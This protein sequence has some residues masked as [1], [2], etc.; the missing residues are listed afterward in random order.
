VRVLSRG[1]THH[2]YSQ[3]EVPFPAAHPLGQAVSRFRDQ[4]RTIFFRALSSEGTLGSGSVM[5]S[6]PRGSPA[7]TCFVD[8]CDR[9]KSRRGFCA[10]HYRR[11]LNDGDPGPA[12]IRTG[13]SQ[14]GACAVPACK[15]SAVTRGW[16][17]AHYQRWKKHGHPGA[18]PIS[19]PPVAPR[20]CG[21]EG[22]ERLHDAKGLCSTHY[23]RLRATGDPGGLIRE[24][25][26]SCVCL[27]EACERDAVVRGWCKGH[28][29]RWAKTGDPET[30]A[31]RPE[32]RPR[33]CEIKGCGRPHYG[34]GLCSSHWARMKTHGD[35]GPAEFLVRR[36]SKEHR[37]LAD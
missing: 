14:I 12:D 3:D 28:Y 23:Q 8:G 33:L 22:C 19:P 31:I 2:N 20:L 4:M 35:P 6:H 32:G 29:V 30:S 9:P 10:A 1:L 27:V 18:T 7:A 15:R 17:Q 36:P 13:S 24:F 11:V 21:V 16:C 25:R 34:K 5:Q 37:R 26:G